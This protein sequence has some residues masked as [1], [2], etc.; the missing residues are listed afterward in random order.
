[1]TSIAG[2]ERIFIMGTNLN[3][4][5]AAA[6]ETLRNLQAAGWPKRTPSGNYI[7]G[8]NTHILSSLMQ[9]GYITGEKDTCLFFLR[10]VVH[11]SAR[12][13]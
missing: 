3:P 6:L 1:M 8:V 10:G 5:Q 12:I 7:T 4:K 11:T 2:S 13:L 9:K